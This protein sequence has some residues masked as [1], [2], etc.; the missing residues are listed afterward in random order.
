MSAP[1]GAPELEPIELGP[2]HL[3]RIA[4]DRGQAEQAHA[5]GMEKVLADAE[6]SARRLADRM[7]GGDAIYGGLCITCEN[8]YALRPEKASCAHKDI[9]EDCWPKGCTACEDELEA[10]IRHR[11]QMVHLI[12]KSSLELR[13]SADDLSDADLDLLDW[14]A[15]RDVRTNVA[16]A[17][18]ALRRI[19]DTLKRRA[20]A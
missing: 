9:C 8:R 4:E 6:A 17:I 5:T 15:I 13:S 1:G 10:G 16:L 11:E 12:I 19:E 14:R 2:E 7:K 3:A 20:R 18:E